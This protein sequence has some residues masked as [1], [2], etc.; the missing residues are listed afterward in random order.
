MKNSVVIHLLVK[1]QQGDSEVTFS[2]FT[3]SCHL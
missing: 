2:V 3:W 1:V